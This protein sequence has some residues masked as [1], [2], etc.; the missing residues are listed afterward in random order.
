MKAENIQVRLSY[1][2]LVKRFPQLLL[3]ACVSL[4]IF[5]CLQSQVFAAQGYRLP[6]PEGKTVMVNQSCVDSI[7]GTGCTHS[8]IPQ[9]KYAIDFECSIGD[10][11]VAIQD[12]TVDRTE[13]EN[14]GYGN[15]IKI[16]HSDGKYSLYAHLKE[17][18]PLVVG[19]S[20]ARG[21]AIGKC[22]DSGNSPDGPHLHLELRPTS[23]YGA[24]PV[25]FDECDNNSRCR[26]GQVYY[27]QSYV[28]LNSIN[29]NVG[30][31]GGGSNGNSANCTN[32]ALTSSEAFRI[33][34]PIRAGQV[35]WNEVISPVTGQPLFR[36]MSPRPLSLGDQIAAV[37]NGSATSG[38]NRRAT[39]GGAVIGNQDIA[40]GTVGL[41][42]G[43][44][45][46]APV[47]GTNYNWLNVDWGNGKLGYSAED[48]LNYVYTAT[49]FVPFN[50]G[51]SSGG[52]GVV[53]TDSTF[54]GSSNS[55][56]AAFPEPSSI[57]GLFSAVVGGVL[58]KLRKKS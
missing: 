15:R 40:W 33:C 18:T 11:V 3:N 39:P 16:R 37:I 43:G 9:I 19:A 55:S 26:D 6:F 30:D 48:Y 1:G 20:V 22:G 2:I 49:R 47:N 13:L 7:D 51:D 21:Q 14:D 29:S 28:S 5:F 53:F 31:N 25:Y 23:S 36:N 42:S 35:M 45:G 46:F 27:P 10:S 12:G 58:V 4:P 8:G 17:P 38:L 56:T 41:Y 50:D 24:V 52:N 54:P 44:F 32:S 34:I 57:L